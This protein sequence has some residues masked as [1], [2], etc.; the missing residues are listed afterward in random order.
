MRCV[1]GSIQSPFNTG[2]RALVAVITIDCPRAASSGDAA[3]L[4]STLSSEVILRAKA[5]RRSAVR[6]YAVIDLIFLTAQ[7][8]ISWLSACQPVP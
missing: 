4:T 2:W 1:P 8:A 7:T 6:P 5:S 3:G